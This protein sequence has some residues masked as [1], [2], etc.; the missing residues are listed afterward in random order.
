MTAQTEPLPSMAALKHQARRLRLVTGRDR[1]THSS[2]LEA[3]AHGRGYRDWNTLSATVRT[4]MQGCPV[5]PGQRVEGRYLGRPFAGTVLRT[6][7]GPERRLWR[8][9]I[10]FDAPVEVAEIEGLSTWRKRVTGAIGPDGRTIDVI[11][12][13]TPHLRV[14]V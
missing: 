1:M 10:A 2:A 12:D 3:I 5:E 6:A 13:G 14:D 8:V 11:S 9:T 4:R 7:P